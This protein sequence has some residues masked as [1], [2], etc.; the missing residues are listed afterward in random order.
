M[1]RLNAHTQNIVEGII[2][3]SAETAQFTYKPLDIVTLGRMFNT[4]DVMIPGLSRRAEYWDFCNAVLS[5]LETGKW[6]TTPY[7]WGNLCRNI[8]T[9]SLTNQNVIDHGKLYIQ[10]RE[11]VLSGIGL[12]SASM[13]DKLVI[14]YAIQTDRGEYT[15]CQ[16][17]KVF[18]D[19][20]IA[21]TSGVLGTEEL[22]DSTTGSF[23][24][25]SGSVNQS[26]TKA[27]LMRYAAIEKFITEKAL[28]NRN[29]V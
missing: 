1:L 24:E 8:N 7:M 11:E 29:L 6:Y 13:Y 9:P 4:V 5:W 26:K 15:L 14:L 23:L 3:S 27:S 12:S 16:I 20:H 19:L 2:R 22:P 17:A 10:R 21:A 28:Q 25:L 18:L